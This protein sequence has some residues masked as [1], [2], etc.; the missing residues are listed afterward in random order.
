[1]F[2]VGLTASAWSHKQLA[3][4]H[5]FWGMHCSGPMSWGACLDNQANLRPFSSLLQS[6]QVVPRSH[7][8]L[9]AQ[10]DG[11][12]AP[13]PLTPSLVNMRQSWLHWKRWLRPTHPTQLLELMAFMSSSKSP[14]PVSGKRG[15]DDGVRGPEH[16][17]AGERE[18]SWRHVKC[19]WLC[20]KTLSEPTNR[21]SIHHSLHQCNWSRYI[22][23]HRTNKDATF[24]KAT[25]ETCWPSWAL[26]SIHRPGVLPCTVLPS[27]WHCNNTADKAAWTG[28]A[29]A[30]GQAGESPTLW[31][32][33]WRGWPVSRAAVPVPKGA[34][35]H[36]HCQ[37]H[38]QN[39]LR[40]D[41]N[42]EEHG[43]RGPWSLQ[44]SW[45]T[46]AF[47]ARCS[48]LICWSREKLQCLETP[49][50]L[51]ALFNVTNPTQQCGCLSCSQ[52]ENV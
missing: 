21:R 6:P 8:N 13:Q 1:M 28:R 32:S 33:W 26:R 43:S 18:N 47:V 49:E 42:H 36:V 38:L 23:G 34:A 37:L 44:S 3:Q 39:L 52:R 48:C 27:P 11:Q 20:E 19:S 10:H 22:F 7:S 25:E 12:C 17:T 5:R 50:D 15:D 51:A 41:R 14:W 40:S 24:T 16:F 4:P 2:T 35:G 46:S 31:S 45:G 9:C 29:T 30:P